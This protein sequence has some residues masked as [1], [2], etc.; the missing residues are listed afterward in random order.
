M[1]GE[2]GVGRGGVEVRVSVEGSE[3]KV[4]YFVAL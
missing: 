2:E 1:K 4:W 3:G